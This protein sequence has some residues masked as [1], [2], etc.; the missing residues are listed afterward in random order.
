VATEKVGAPICRFN[1]AHLINQLKMLRFY[2]KK[3]C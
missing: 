2:N 3:Q 1:V